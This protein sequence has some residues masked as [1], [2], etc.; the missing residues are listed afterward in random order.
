M[1]SASCEGA[2]SIAARKQVWHLKE[3]KKTLSSS[4]QKKK[5]NY[6]AAGC[7]ITVG[8]WRFRSRIRHDNQISSYAHNSRRYHL[9]Q[10]CGAHTSGFGHDKRSYC[11]FNH[12]HNYH[13][14]CSDAANHD[15]YLVRCGWCNDNHPRLHHAGDRV[16][17]FQCNGQYASIGCLV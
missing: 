7:P 12:N 2:A 13:C 15:L 9:F 17:A 1:N 8:S 16:D 11:I 14:H 4:Q 5:K 3:K 10:D 6:V